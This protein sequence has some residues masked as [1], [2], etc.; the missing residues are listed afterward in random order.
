MLVSVVTVFS[1]CATVQELELRDDGSGEGELVV[2]LRPL[3]VDYYRDLALSFGA[4]DESQLRVFDLEAIRAGFAR[5]PNVVLTDSAVDDEGRLRLGFSFDDIATIM[6]PTTGD[7][8]AFVNPVSYAASGET[9]T[10]SI[11][12]DR[13]I[14]AMALEI[15][16]IADMGSVGLLLPPEG[17]DMTAD[18]YAEYVAWALEDYAVADDPVEVIKM[19]TIELQVHVP[20]TVLSV[21]GGT[22]TETGASFR[23]SIPKL[24]TLTEPVSYRLT[25]RV[26]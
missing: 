25:Y 5:R 6:Q 4:E 13:S 12:L 9:R 2:E 18:E 21:D 17:G 19:S 24:L 16:P 10:L 1:S 8:E 11:S 7:P 22:Q 20:G 15:A 26:R 14:I 3:F 23:I